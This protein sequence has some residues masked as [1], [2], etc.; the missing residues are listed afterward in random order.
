MCWFKVLQFFKK[1]LT[2]EH[3]FFWLEHLSK[4]E[5]EG[6]KTPHVVL[7]VLYWYF[8]C[9][10]QSHS[11]QFLPP[12]PHEPLCTPGEQPFSSGCWGGEIKINTFPAVFFLLFGINNSA[13]SLSLIVS[14]LVP[15]LL[16]R[17]YLPR[18]TNF[19]WEPWST[20]CHHW[21]KPWW[22]KCWVFRNAV[23]VNEKSLLG[24]CQRS[25]FPISSSR[26]LP[27]YTLSGMLNHR[28]IWSS[29]HIKGELLS[30]SYRCIC[31]CR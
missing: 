15:Q 16:R 23:A 9:F 19:T 22:K 24:S 29:L 18:M 25:H 20:F 8:L 21:L 5:R 10:L 2:R 3:D 6:K 11:A 12:C 27:A 14:Y 13:V 4:K 7:S 26:W 30:V 31:H 1:K 17:Q 28:E